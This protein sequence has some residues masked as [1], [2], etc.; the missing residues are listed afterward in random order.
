MRHKCRCSR[1][2]WFASVKCTRPL[3]QRIQPQLIFQ[4]TA[5]Y[6]S[7]LF[8][9]EDTD[10]ACRSCCCR[11]L[12]YAGRATEQRRTLDRRHCNNRRRLW[13]EHWRICISFD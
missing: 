7:S 6:S 8:Q 9:H 2:C 10:N 5:G 11:G 3:H 4:V 1:R 13:R 12:R